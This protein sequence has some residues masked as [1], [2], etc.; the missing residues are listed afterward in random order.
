MICRM[1]IDA[2]TKQLTSKSLTPANSAKKPLT[3]IRLAEVGPGPD[4]IPYRSCKQVGV[5][6][7]SHDD[8]TVFEVTLSD[9]RETLEGPWDLITA[10]L[11]R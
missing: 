2:N 10:K 1:N 6:S 5:M 4:G 3:A 7:C 9:E 11:P 8:G